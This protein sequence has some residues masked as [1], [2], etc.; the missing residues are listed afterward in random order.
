MAILEIKM[1]GTAF[2]AVFVHSFAS[3]QA[4]AQANKDKYYLHKPESERVAMLK[5][6]YKAAVKMIKLAEKSGNNQ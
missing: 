1:D 6:V 5:D 4:F 3:A 2:T